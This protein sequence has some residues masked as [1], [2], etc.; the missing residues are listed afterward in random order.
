[1]L[2]FPCWALL[3]HSLCCGVAW[4]TF[5]PSA[6]S[7]SQSPL[8]ACGTICLGPGC[9]Q[10][11]AMTMA[12]Q[13]SRVQQVS[14]VWWEPQLLCRSLAFCGFQHGPCPRAP[15]GS[16]LLGVMSF[17]IT[18]GA[19]ASLLSES[20]RPFL[21]GCP[22]SPCLWPEW[23]GLPG[24]VDVAGGLETTWSH[25]VPLVSWSQRGAIPSRA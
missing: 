22:P 8:C 7:S 24:L 3:T 23:G 10:A 12:W 14:G 20:V 17:T 9:S 15:L 13:L 4:L 16:P 21:A 1:M 2:A 18:D 19:R 5:E 6:L 11:L 25:P